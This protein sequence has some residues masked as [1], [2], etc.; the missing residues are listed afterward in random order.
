MRDTKTK[1]TKKWIRVRDVIWKMKNGGKEITMIPNRKIYLQIQYNAW[2]WVYDLYS[3][4]Y[5]QW[6]DA[7]QWPE[8]SWITY[9]WVIR[10]Y[11][12][13]GPEDVCQKPKD[14]WQ[15]L[16]ESKITFL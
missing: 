3:T 16:E 10:I 12:N 15:G 7:Y 14:A 1:I 13:V 11:C 4:D 9:L 8:T 5:R 2:F 6:E